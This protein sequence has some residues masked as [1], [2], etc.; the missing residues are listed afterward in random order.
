M[1]QSI[2]VL[3]YH[4]VGSPDGV[5]LSIPADD[6]DRQMKFLAKK[7]INTISASDLWG[8]L[9][10]ERRIRLPAVCITFDD[11]FVDN[12]SVAHP[13]LK[14]YAHK[15]ALFMA[16]TLVRPPESAAA[17]DLV[18]FNDS[19]TLARRGDLSHFLSESELIDM[20]KSGVWEVYSHTQRHNQVFIS[21][22]VTGTY[23]DTDNHWGIL[24]AYEN[25]LESGC[26]PV[27]KRRSGL[28]Q[29]ALVPVVDECG[30]LKQPVILVKES[31]EDYIARVKADLQSSLAYISRLFPQQPPLLCWPW[32][33][34]DDGLEALAREVGY[35]GAFRTDSGANYPGM[36]PMRIKRF[37][38]KKK[39]VFRF[40][41]GLWL[42]Q[43]RSLAEV[44]AFFRN[45]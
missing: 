37:P 38:V 11:G 43:N 7:Q 36:D 33:S 25:G 15:A 42:R 30:R 24:S 1:G 26:W 10:G 18:S 3:Y 14:K 23:P 32:G 28:L 31:E 21:E 44:Y 35:C 45:R 8:W 17:K 2:P 9:K 16:T 13:I 19:H 12:Y 34:A 5:H 39:D 40:S 22:E 20:N 29:P 27:F 41:F 4:R 6:F